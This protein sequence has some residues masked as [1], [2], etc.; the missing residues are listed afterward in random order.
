MIQ[1]RESPAVVRGLTSL[2][3]EAAVMPSFLLANA[4]HMSVFHLINQ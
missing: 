4:L 3:A 2:K 1:V